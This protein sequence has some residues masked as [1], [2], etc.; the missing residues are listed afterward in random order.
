MGYTATTVFSRICSAKLERFALSSP[1]AH[2][3]GRVTRISKFRSSSKSSHAGDVWSMRLAQEGA[4]RFF[5]ALGFSRKSG[6]EVLDRLRERRQRVVARDILRRAEQHVQRMQKRL[7]HAPWARWAR[8]EWGRRWCLRTWR[9]AVYG[10][11]GRGRIDFFQR[12]QQ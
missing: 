2:R 11:R 10:W 4:D 1:P 12:C 6:R 9:R 7:R 5:C 3:A 8:V